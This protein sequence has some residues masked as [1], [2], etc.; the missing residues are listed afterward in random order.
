MAYLRDIAYLLLLT[1]ISPWLAWCAV[2][3]GK[4]RE[5]WN[6]KLL[7]R[8][9]RRVGDRP[10][11]WFH[12]VSVGEVNLLAPLIT[13]WEREFPDWDCVISTTTRTGYELA[14]KKY[15]P[16]QVI[17]APLDFSWSVRRALRRIRPN[18]LVLAELEVWPNW[19]E[20]ARSRNIP[21]AVVNGR[22]S[23]KSFRGYQR[24]RSFVSSTFAQLQLIAV[25]SE[26]YAE[27]FRALGAL[28]ENVCTTGSVKFDGVETQRDNA[29][30]QRL[31]RLAGI[32][33]DDL[34]FVAGS[35]QEGEETAALD[36]FLSHTSR[37]PK[38]RLLLVPRHPE[39]FDSVAAMLTAR[40]IP[41]QRR[42]NLE[43]EGPSIS[44]RV[45]LV[46]AVGELGA[47]WGT[48][49]IAFV[50]GSLTQRG[51][52]NMIEPAAYGAAI[53]FGPNTWNFKDVVERMLAADAAVVVRHSEDLNRFV[54]RM[55][56]LPTAR[57]ELGDKAQQLVL[58]Q[59]GAA[60]RT[61]ALLAALISQQPRSGWSALPPANAA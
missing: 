54:D 6:E 7:G 60:D 13:R 18:L 52:Q 28:P 3:K 26:E 8:V 9:P 24:L 5:G 10:C 55:L 20:A 35:T 37:H 29:K 23:E 14:H 53:A 12:A 39:R 57:Q 46:D 17:Y 44:A 61:I 38:L 45:L 59:T 41:F 43:K 21:V 48:A 32:K 34:V 33:P 42:S 58:T 50:G 56:S 40:Q 22:L 1:A 47:W 16:R 27:R 51:G 25:Q 31:A 2:R 49:Q 4:Y 11:V 19:I 30:T 15:A 36:A